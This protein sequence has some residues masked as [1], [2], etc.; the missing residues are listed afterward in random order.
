MQMQMQMQARCAHI[1]SRNASLKRHATAR[2]V[3]VNNLQPESPSSSSSST[4]IRRSA[5]SQDRLPE[6]PIDPLFTR[7]WS[8]RA[9]LVADGR[10]DF[11]E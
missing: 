10:F 2:I 9:F 6:H 1:D 11:S 8:A 3:D 4:L 5:M 7:R